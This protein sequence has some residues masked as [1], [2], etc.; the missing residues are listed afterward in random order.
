MKAVLLCGGKGTRMSSN[1]DDIPKPM[2]KIGNKPIVVH[3]MN[4]L[5]EK[6]NH[7]IDEF[8]LALGYK[9]DYIK[10]YF[11]HDFEMN[12][13]IYLNYKRRQ[14]ILLDDQPQNSYNIILADTGLDSLTGTRLQRL[15]KYLSKEKNFMV[16]YGDILADVDIQLLFKTYHAIMKENPDICG[17]MTIHEAQSRFGIVEFSEN[18][19]TSI[20]EKPH[21][22]D[23]IN[24]GFFIFSPEIFSYIPS[25][26]CSIEQEP[27]TG[28]IS[29]RRLAVFR[30]QGQYQPLDTQKELEILNKMFESGK[31]YW[32]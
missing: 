10:H 26:N 19:V 12:S 16:C 15:E 29:D 22:H 6:S 2:V 14:K 30:H 18:V 31:A 28:L 32:T 11:I 1:N 13:D 9:S 17:I 23:T 8:I 20:K 4:Y 5:Y 21:G 24:I 25:K 3:L 7:T 27:L